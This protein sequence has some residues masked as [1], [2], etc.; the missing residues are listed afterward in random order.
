[1]EINKTYN[2]ISFFSLSVIKQRMQMCCSPYDS[3]LK[4]AKTIYTNEGGRAFYRSYTTALSMNIPYQMAMFVTYKKVQE[5]LNPQNEY[6]PSV[7]FLAG[8]VAGGAASFITMPLDVC[9]TLLNTQESAVLKATQK[10]EVRGL[11]NAFKTV[12]RMA[13]WRGLFNGL[14]PRVLYQVGTYSTAE[15]LNSQY[16]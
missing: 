10:Q 15:D 1:L 12:W 4:C 7:H 6:K 14:T 3:T 9:K 8:A 2:P 11:W 13:G 5:K 16:F